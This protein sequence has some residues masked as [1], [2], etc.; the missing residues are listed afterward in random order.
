MPVTAAVMFDAVGL[1]TSPSGQVS[2]LACTGP[3]LHVHKREA[4]VR[5]RLIVAEPGLAHA[6][7]NVNAR[8]AIRLETPNDKATSPPRTAALT[9]GDENEVPRSQVTAA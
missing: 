4:A 8:K 1:I 9:L 6:R 7:A 3:H 2:G 5:E